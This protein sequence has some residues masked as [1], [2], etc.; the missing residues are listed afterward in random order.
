[1]GLCDRD[2]KVEF[3]AQSTLSVSAGVACGCSCFKLFALTVV[4]NG[5]CLAEKQSPLGG[6]AE[7]VIRHVSGGLRHRSGFF[8]SAI[9]DGGG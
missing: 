4:G 3:W 6:L 9:A 5:E 1:L 8:E 2:L 7:G